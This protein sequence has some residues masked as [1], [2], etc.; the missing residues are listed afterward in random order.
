MYIMKQYKHTYIK[1][2]SSEGMFTFSNIVETQEENETVTEKI[3]SDGK[4]MS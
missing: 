4:E 2:F 3:I 1:G